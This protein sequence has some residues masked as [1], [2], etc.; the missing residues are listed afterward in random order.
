MDHIIPNLFR[1]FWRLWLLRLPDDL[2]CYSHLIDGKFYS[3]KV[4]WCFIMTQLFF[5]SL[6][7]ARTDYFHFTVLKPNLFKVQGFWR[8]CLNQ[9][10]WKCS[11]FP[12]EFSLLCEKN[13]YISFSFIFGNF[14]IFLIY[15]LIIFSQAHPLNI[16]LH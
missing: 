4:C 14:F 7:V 10:E 5:Y 12:I 8:V 16:C 3:L 13:N 1:M 9:Y 11:A 15:Y 2:Y 6:I